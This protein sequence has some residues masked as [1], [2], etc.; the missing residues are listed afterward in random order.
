MPGPRLV[1][2][3]PLRKLYTD[4][5]ISVEDIA[6]EHGCSVHTIKKW[7]Q[8]WGIKRGCH[9]KTTAWNKG[10][11]KETNEAVAKMA[12][13]RTGEKNWRFGKEP[14]NKGKTA[15]TD[16][17]LARISVNAMGRQ[18][19]DETKEKQRLAK[20]GKRG[21]EC[22]NFKTGKSANS[23]SGYYVVSDGATNLYEHRIVAS[24]SLG[25]EL[26]SSECVHHVDGD[27]KNNSPDNLIVISNSLHLR[28]HRNCFPA[29]IEDQVNWLKST[30]EKFEVCFENKV[31]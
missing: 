20:L 12:E 9:C 16:P 24:K 6:K 5:C 7:V 15:Q 22:N 31:H 29:S 10:L 23:I 25:R 8:V 19:S 18:V 1:E 17:T 13:G 26:S 30:G 2:E 11:T 28:L 4:D 27:K 21:A 3:E 14:W